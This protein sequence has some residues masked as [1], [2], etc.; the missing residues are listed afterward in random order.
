MRRFRRRDIL[1]TTTALVLGLRAGATLA[2]GTPMHPD[3]IL[4][5]GRFT[6][7]DRA[8]PNPEAVAITDGMFSAVGEARDILAARGPATKVIALGGRR[9]IPGLIDS[10]IHVIRGGLYYNIELRWDGVPTLADA[11]AMLKRQAAI[12]PPPQWVRVVGGFTEHQFTEKRLP[13]LDEINA[14]AP[15]T[16]VFILHLYD[17]ALLNRAALRAVGYTKDTPNPPG[18]EIQRDANGDPTGLLLAKPNALIL[19]ATLAKG[20]KLPPEVQL[21]STRH[22]MR[23]LNRLG[24]TSVIDAGG[25]FQNYPD[26]YAIIEKLHA[27]GELT[28]RIAYNLFTQKAGQELA[29]FTRWTKMAK[30]GQGDDL[31]RVNGAGEML[32]FSA[33][34]FEDFR[35]PRPD[36]APNMEGDLEQ[37]VRLLAEKRFPWRLH[38]T[39]DETISRALDVFEKVDKEIP[40]QGI[41]WFFDHAETIS[42][43][44]IDR[45]A[46]L[47]GGIAVQH[48]MAFQG[49]YFIERYGAKAAAATPPIKRMLASGVPV[50]AGTDATRVASYNPWVSLSWLVTGKSVGGTRLYP[51]ANRLDRTEALRLW[52]EAN[53]WFSTEPGKKGQ[54][55]VG[56]LA[57]LAVLSADYLGVPE[58]EIAHLSSVLTLLG[59]K[60]VHGAGDFV[61]LAPPLP[62]AAPDWSPVRTFGGYQDRAAIGVQRAAFSACG[63]A[64]SCAV[65][66]HDHA[67]AWLAQSPESEHQSFWGAL[68]CSCW[69]V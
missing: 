68:G 9:A 66:D 42:D 14:A 49:E 13:T 44:N 63:C 19:Y 7:L 51:P 21:N 4:V 25:G 35:E 38:A 58:D 20:P 46:K 56:Q 17:R 16:P 32:V 5:N 3:L 12:T 29:D 64:H 61:G 30:P 18:G 28:L 36:M 62:P 6:T 69:A 41:H 37:V 22:F 31:Y 53:T 2:Q 67:R 59:G 54:I 40:L 55:A 52:T 45:I 1:A 27:D 15:E 24:V 50:G 34:D 23:E 60:I 39:Y 8:N 11:M 10:H 47:G 43:R 33:A 48:R 65:H 57:D 26:D